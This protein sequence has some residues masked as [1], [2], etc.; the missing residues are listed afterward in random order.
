M[1]T[2]YPI[3][4]LRLRTYVALILYQTLYVMQFYPD[5]LRWSVEGVYG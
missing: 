4:V 2:I 1:I 3:D 5:C